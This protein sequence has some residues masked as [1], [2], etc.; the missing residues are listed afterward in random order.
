MYPISRTY[1]WP[2]I[3]LI[4]FILVLI[5]YSLDPADYNF[6]PK[7]PFYWITGYKCPGCGSQR[8]V[9]HLLNLDFKHAFLSNPLLV[10]AIPYILLGFAF[11]Y[12]RLRER[13]PRVRKILFGKIAII[14]MF[15]IVIAYWILR[16]L[17]IFHQ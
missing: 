16:N 5:Y 14:S 13:Y 17:P 12:T 8:A 11:D 6:F 15:V 2:L 9:H 4:L 1:K 7:C 3:A 10:T